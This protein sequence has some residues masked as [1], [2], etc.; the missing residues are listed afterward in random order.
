ME[1][2]GIR[3]QVHMAESISITTLLG[4]KGINLSHPAI[5]SS[6]DG[7]VTSAGNGKFGM[8]AIRDANGFSHEILHTHAQ[9]VSVGDPVAAGQP[10]WLDG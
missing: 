3:V 2:L 8:M 1:R 7:I 9:H 5:R 6:V 4:R 10:D